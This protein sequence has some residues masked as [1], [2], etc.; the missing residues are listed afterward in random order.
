LGAEGGAEAMVPWRLKGP[1]AFIW[2]R[3]CLSLLG[4]AATKNCRAA[5]G[6]GE[7]GFARLCRWGNELGLGLQ[8][9]RCR[10]LGLGAAGSRVRV[11][12]RVRVCASVEKKTNGNRRQKK[13]GDN[14]K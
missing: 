4:A 10:D 7:G 3:F 5:R 8:A 2:S 9:W 6:L 13:N 1:G 12:V 14:W 11:R